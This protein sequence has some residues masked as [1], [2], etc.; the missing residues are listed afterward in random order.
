MND[1][2]RENWH[3]TTKPPDL[4]KTAESKLRKIVDGI[5]AGASFLPFVYKIL[6][7]NFFSIK[8]IL[9]I[10][11][12]QKIER[13]KTETKNISSQNNLMCLERCFSMKSQIQTFR[14]KNICQ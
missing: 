10:C 1:A 3:I 14:N 13:K 5:F 8:S 2:A 6:V 12:K 7:I 11:R 9:S 4:S